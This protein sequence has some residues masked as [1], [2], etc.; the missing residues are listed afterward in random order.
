MYAII[1]EGKGSYY[2]SAVFAYYDETDY[3]DYLKQ[4]DSAYKKYVAVF[5]R[6]KT[7]ILKLPINPIK[8]RLI[9]T[10]VII[11]DTDNVDW[12]ILDGHGN[13]TVAFSSREEIENLLNTE[14]T[15]NR[16][17]EYDKSYPYNAVRSIETEKDIEDFYCASGRLH[18]ANLAEMN[19]F[20]NSLCVL[21][22]NVW[23][24]SIEM[25][26]KNVI[27]FNAPSLEPY[28]DNSWFSSTI[29]IGNGEITL[30]NEQ[31]LTP[32]KIRDFNTYFKAKEVKYR[33]IPN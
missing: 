25:Q 32:E 17:T 16:F 2:T 15:D 19:Y 12:D 24:C 11:T 4:L 30:V 26:F 3:S 8:N 23:G 1:R 7:V 6:E 21:F 13:G 14:N 22:K 31:L 20:N 28:E 29:F 33:I 5:N 18:D 10:Q 27:E 9:D